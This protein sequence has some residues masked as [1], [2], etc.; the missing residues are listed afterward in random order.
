MFKVMTFNINYYG[1]KYGPWSVRRQ[2]IADAIQEAAPD[3]VALQAVKQAPGVHSAFNQAAQLTE[4]LPEYHYV[5]F[6]PSIAYGGGL[7]DGSAFLSRVRISRWD[8]FK[9]TLHPNPE[10]TN[11]RIVLHATVDLPDG[12]LHLLNAHFSWVEREGQSNVREAL[13]Y[14]NS[15]AR[16]AILIGDMNASPNA[17]HLNL[18]RRAGWSD[19]WEQLRP[20]EDGCTFES[21]E[22][23]LRID[24][25]WASGSIKTKVK[26]IK[27]VAGCLGPQGERCSDH[28]GLLVTL[29]T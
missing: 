29:E 23:K 25:A 21:A 8:Y 28:M 5:V 19:L 26:D 9:L 16:R 10:D 14:V 22:P 13:P 11:P 4:L 27:V 20:G 7:A 18:L 1:T 6:Q 3:V 24:Y 17:E 12:P 15:F 2:L